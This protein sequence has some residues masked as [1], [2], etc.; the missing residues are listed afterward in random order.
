MVAHTRLTGTEAHAAHVERI[1]AELAAL[2][3]TV[4]RHRSRAF[5]RW[6]CTGARLAVLPASACADEV[7][8]AVASAYPYS[9]A[10]G[11]G[12]V[13]GRLVRVGPFTPWSRAAGAIAVVACAHPS[14][15]TSAL[16]SAWDAQ[17]AAA[18]PQAL[19]NLVVSATVFGPD[20]ARARAAGVLAVVV[21]WAS[22]M[23]P[24]LAK[25]Q[26]L[27]F[28]KPYADIPAVWVTCDAVLRAADKGL[29]GRLTLEANLTP[30]ITVDT[31]YATIPS[32]VAD[33]RTCVLVVTHTDGTN[34]LEE[35]GH[36]GVLRL[37]R[38]ASQ[39]LQLQ[40]S[41]VVVFTAGHLRI[42]AVADKGQATS[43]FLDAHPE[44]WSG[45]DG[46]LKAVG[47]IVIEHL[48]ALRLDPNTLQPTSETESELIYATTRDL[49]EVVRESWRTTATAPPM[50]VCPGPIV[51]FGEGEP[52]HERDIPTVSLVTGPA[53]LLT[54]W[55]TRDDLVNEVLKREQIESFERILVRMDALAAEMGSLGQPKHA[56][57]AAK[58]T[59]GLYLAGTLLLNRVFEYWN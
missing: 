5:T 31:V 23:P 1:A 41:V 51:M 16:V 53:H 8:V 4:G 12:G 39:D 56:S 44:L 35:N 6:E 33:T 36:E 40:H 10:T 45:R 57:I 15:A 34:Q 19:S 42:P 54:E 37:A 49:F 48:G 58:L 24:A 38:V 50:I 21:V 14:V 9:G 43:A 30:G 27:P 32:R 26:Y 18:W 55:D 17:Q 7:D 3:L 20:L 28:T 22:A 52:L 11:S 25:D 2:G 29:R 47:G 13:E 59:A 46:G